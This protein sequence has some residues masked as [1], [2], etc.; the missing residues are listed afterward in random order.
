MFRGCAVCGGILPT[1][2][3]PWTPKS[4]LHGAVRGGRGASVDWLIRFCLTSALCELKL[5][6]HFSLGP[7]DG[8]TGRATHFFRLPPSAGRLSLTVDGQSE[9]DH[10]LPM[11][12]Q[13]AS[14]RDHD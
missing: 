11:E 10:G 13:R 9:A 14:T 8:P 1:D 4:Q 3:L 12:C 7:A 2:M 5:S 6:H